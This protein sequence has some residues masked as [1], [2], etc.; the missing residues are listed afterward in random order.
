MHKLKQAGS[1]DWME[2]HVHESERQIIRLAYNKDGLN[3]PSIIEKIY[4]ITNGDAIMVQQMLD[5]IRCGLHSIYKYQRAKNTY[6]HQV[7]LEPW[8][9]VLVHA[10]GAKMDR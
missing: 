10:I 8:D 9:M 5:S 1:S 7:D 6:L 2:E 4:E 3:G